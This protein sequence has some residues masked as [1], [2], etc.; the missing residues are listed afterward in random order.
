MQG[1]TGMRVEYRRAGGDFTPVAFLT[2][3]RAGPDLRL[4][5]AR[6]RQIRAVFIRKNAEFGN[7]SPN[8]P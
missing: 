1:M 3:H 5:G 6:I 2:K 4:P 8:Y 7:W